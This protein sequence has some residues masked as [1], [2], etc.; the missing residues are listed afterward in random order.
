MTGVTP[1][2][3]LKG[4]RER[5][6]AEYL[7]D[8]SPADAYVRAGYRVG[9]RRTARSAA[10]RLLT[11]AAVRAAIT[12]AQAARRDHLDLDADGVV[13]RFHYLYL[14]AVT[15][16]D[17]SAAAVALQNVARLLGL[18]DRPMPVS[19]RY[20]A[21]DVERLREELRAAGFELPP[22]APHVSPQ[23]QPFQ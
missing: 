14:L 16:G 15:T 1:P 17:L 9:S 3:T 4:R 5:F 10:Q 2:S 18:Y 7:R 21:A 13:R 22:A 12:R 20:A 11:N 6:V 8:L 23:E 19:P